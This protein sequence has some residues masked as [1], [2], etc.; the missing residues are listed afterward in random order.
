MSANNA[1]PDA[2][3][4]CTSSE[5]PHNTSSRPVINFRLRLHKKRFFSAE[6]A[7]E[8]VLNGSDIED[9]D[10]IDEVTQVADAFVSPCSSDDE[11]DEPGEEPVC[12][13][14]PCGDTGPSRAS[15]SYEETKQSG[16]VREKFV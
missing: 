11:T 5:I 2:D 9:D 1:N 13:A 12:V 7:V 14:V 16:S 15:L 3:G 4:P 8:A 10:D 6:E